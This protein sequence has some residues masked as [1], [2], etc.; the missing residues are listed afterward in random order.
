[1]SAS[2]SHAHRP[3]QGPLSPTTDARVEQRPV[4]LDAVRITGGML[5]DW[6]T[7]NRDVSLRSNL[8]HLES[9][10]VVDNLKLAAG[11][12][13]GQFRGPVFMDAAVYKS[14]EAAVWEVFLA[15]DETLEAWLAETVD[16]LA[17]VQADDGYINSYIQVTHPDRRYADLAHSHEVFVPGFLIQA[18]IAAERTGHKLAP[19][20]MQMA[21]RYADHLVDAFLGKREDLD[22]HPGIEMPL[23]ELFRQTGEKSYLAVAEQFLRGRGQHKVDP[24]GRRRYYQDHASVLDAE[25]EVGHAVR[26]LFLDAGVVDLYMETGD[27][28]LLDSSIRRWEDLVATKTYITGGMGSRHAE[29]AFGDGFELPPD[30]AY[31]ESCA[32][33]ASILWSWR[34][35]LATGEARFADLIERT[36][37]NV[38]AAS[39]AK[40]GCHFFY[41]NP[42]QRR[43]D[44]FES[45]DHG[46]R[47][48][49]FWCPCCPPNIVRMVS[50]LAHYV[51]S[52]ADDG[53]FVHQFA[54]A[55]LEAE[56]P[57]GR[58]RLHVDTD[59]PWEPEVG[60]TIDDAPAAAWTLSLRL[61]AWCERAELT[62]NGEAIAPDPDARGYLG[63]T[64]VWRAGDVVRFVMDMPA[65]LTFPD[66]RIDATRGCVAIERG[67][68]VYCLEQV[69][70]AAGVDIADL[71][72]AA[73][74]GPTLRSHED[75]VLGHTMLIE[76][77]AVALSRPPARGL[78]YHRAPGP[79]THR[80]VRAI[81]VP[82]YQW[83]NRDGGPMRVWIPLDT[84]VNIA[85]QAAE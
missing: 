77:E 81:A 73:D 23:I 27:R 10:G 56:I 55:S 60:V 29:E 68:L 20:L 71:A 12:T 3:V 50:T 72:I 64:R 17:R 49:W 51:F 69:D 35:L 9:D 39:T 24:K 1:M 62:I 52:K 74:V 82:Y 78:P 57:A 8:G 14:L 80:S 15:P 37:F 30:R 84:T 70:Q 76:T 41:A 36:L 46:R 43:H 85:R 79:V 65:R 63:I 33:F 58:V 22:G 4:G 6:Q 47:H 25:T 26:A 19:R 2:S 61:P 42:L 67:P 5:H 7:L 13:T 66:D 21:R 54:A 44:H 75:P 83:D 16:L 48:E 45:D 11:E 28:A 38:F 31:A 53:I 34:L 59:Y 18:A 40:D 32:A